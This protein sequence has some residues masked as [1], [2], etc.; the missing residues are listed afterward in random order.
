MLRFASAGGMPVMHAGFEASSIASNLFGDLK[1]YLSTCRLS[2]PVIIHL[3]DG[4]ITARRRLVVPGLAWI[5]D[6]S[7]PAPLTAH[8]RIYATGAQTIRQS[9]I[10]RLSVAALSGRHLRPSTALAVEQFRDAWKGS[11]R[12]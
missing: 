3:L 7:G 11:K 8:T 1:R 10:G 5:L 6:A 2:R 9:R 4:S 12:L